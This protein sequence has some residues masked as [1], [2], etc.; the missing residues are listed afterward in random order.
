MASFLPWAWVLIERTA[1]ARGERILDIAC[2]TGI[3]AR[4]AKA[5]VGTEAGGHRR[6]RPDAGHGRAWRRPS[7][8]ARATPDLPLGAGEQ[9]DVVLCQQGLQ[10]FPDKP[11][12]AR[13][14]RRAVA[15]GGRL[16][17]ATWRPDA[18][19]P[20]FGELR[21]IADAISVR[22]WTCATASARPKRSSACWRVGIQ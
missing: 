2:G 13:Q 21:A 15:P 18:E 4:T 8:G 9:F 5:S 10:F 1:L 3:V 7:T 16:G 11:A 17:V 14:F 22:S 12:A 6:E 19:I 20:M